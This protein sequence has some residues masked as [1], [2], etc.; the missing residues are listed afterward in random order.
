MPAEEAPIRGS[1][2][3][4]VT[5]VEFADFECPFSA[6]VSKTLAQLLAEYRDDV[7]LVYRHNP[8]DMHPQAMRAALAAEAAREQGKFWGMHDRMF[9]HQPDLS[10]ATLEGYARELDLD[11]AAYRDSL[12]KGSGKARIQRDVDLGRRFGVWGT[13]VF[14]VNGRMLRGAQ[15][16][17]TWRDLLRVEVGK[18]DAKLAAGTPRDRLYAAL[19]AG[20]LAN[21]PA[22]PQAQA[23][24]PDPGKRFRVDIAGAPS[25]GASDAAVTIV[26]WADLE[27][28]FCGR[29]EETLA[30][31][32][33]AH[34]GRVRVVWRD[35]PLP[36]LH[37]NAR[38]AAVAARAAGAQ[39]KFWEMHDRI[40]AN[41]KQMDRA[42]F[43]RLARDLGLDLPRFRAA[44]DSHAL[45]AAIDA[46]V[47]A[48][49]CLG[50]RGTPSFF[51]NGRYLG[52][53][54]PFETFDSKVA[55]EAAAADALLAAGTPPSAVYDAL[56]KQA[57]SPSGP[58]DG[59]RPA[60]LSKGKPP[61]RRGA[62]AAPARPGP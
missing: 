14:F 1:A 2:R 34:G 56:M 25:R 48:G 50:V 54:Q 20:G 10:P 46:D 16:I 9:A 4:K 51:N 37:P 57:E 17:E 23:Q 43:E 8:L 13:P 12:Q 45:E 39:G 33:D 30:R 21:N 42:A 38:A 60:K 49:I 19:T 52:G 59:A 35:F 29:A 11:M 41:Q 15:S 32:L 58:A 40:L 6:R 47:S 44:L 22:A 26:E 53:A 28:P 31:L 7:A 61:R 27:C 62:I 24:G 55:E 3:P 18:A 5:I 36:A